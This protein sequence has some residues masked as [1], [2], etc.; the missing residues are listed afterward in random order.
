MSAT[1]P[2]TITLAGCRLGAQRALPL[3]PGVMVFGMAFGAAAAAKGLTLDQAVLM[4]A[5]V[6]AGASQMVALEV[7]REAW[8]LP[9]VLGVAAITATV[10]ARM[11]LMG[12]ALASAMRGVPKPVNALNLFLFTD[13]S[14]LV[15]TRYQAEGGRDIGVMLGTGITLWFAWTAVTLP[16]YLVAALVPEPRRFGLDLLMPVF[17]VAMLV[18]IWK[19][20][21]RALPWLV[22][23]LAALAAQAALPGYA[24]IVVGALS[25]AFAAGM[26]SDDEP[27]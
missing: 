4:S 11:I 25:G 19:G 7:W 13:A 12:A 17:F 18:P 5:F 9:T 20:P 15:G 27:R 10:N 26:M 8:S 21:R 14:W 23:G 1:A 16:G 22:A 6:F 24:Y 3:L 2:A